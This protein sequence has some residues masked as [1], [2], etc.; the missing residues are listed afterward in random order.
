MSALT[1][2]ANLAPRVLSLVRIVSAYLFLLHG[3]AKHLG[4]P[5]IE[6]MAATPATSL[7]GIAGWM[8]LVGGTL[9]LVGLF[10]RPVAFVLSGLMAFAYF[11]AHAPT[12]PLFPLMNGG[13]SAV[14]FSFLF[15]YFSVAGAGPWS[16]DAL[17][18]RGG[19]AP[20]LARAPSA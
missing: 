3:T 15:L 5:F 13:E 7:S 19:A 17:R 20:R 9:L 14:L 18:A 11:I 1:L 12:A 6:R 10:T 4:V 8:E 2:P 16:I